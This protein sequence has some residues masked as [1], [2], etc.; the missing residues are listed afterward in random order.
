MRSES[1]GF[2]EDSVAD[3]RMN[4]AAFDYIDVGPHQIPYIAHETG[5]IEDRAPWLHVPGNP[6]RYLRFSCIATEPNTRILR[7]P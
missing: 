2:G 1:Y 7:Q 4:R 6:R 5:E 3:V